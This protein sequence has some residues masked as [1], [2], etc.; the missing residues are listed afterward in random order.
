MDV[1][2]ITSR[3]R[4]GKNVVEYLQVKIALAKEGVE[5]LSALDNETIDS[6]MEEICK[7]T[8]SYLVDT[9]SVNS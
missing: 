1:L 8:T 6:P 3:D 4:L 9:T 2:I 5:I 7:V